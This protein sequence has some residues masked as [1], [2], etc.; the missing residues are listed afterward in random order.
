MRVRICIGVLIMV[1][2][3]MAGCAKGPEERSEQA[4]ALLEEKY[5]ESFIVTEYGNQI[6]GAGYYTVKAYAREY[7]ELPF[8]VRVDDDGKHFSDNYVERRVAQKISSQVLLN[9]ASL[10]GYTYIF[11]QVPA[12]VLD[13][14]DA[15]ISAEDYIAKNPANLITIN[16]TYCPI[17]DT[18]ESLYDSLAGA[19]KGLD[20]LQGMIVLNIAD[21]ETL[22]E[23]Q[24]FC[25]EKGSL[26]GDY[27]ALENR[28]RSYS[29]RYSD[30]RLSQSREEF[31]GALEGQMEGE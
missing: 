3:G 30:G 9:L 28:C 4:E 1:L 16:L 17:G 25:D 2:A 15:D 31:L 21:E 6:V 12:A 22:R 29:I 27:K 5:G 24:M 11:T 8:T 23:I 26:D 7:P 10:P 18:A 20:F 13:I 19:L 14:T